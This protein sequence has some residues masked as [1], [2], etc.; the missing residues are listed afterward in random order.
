MLYYLDESTQEKVRYAVPADRR[1]PAT[2][3][4]DI[5]DQN[6]DA[7]PFLAYAFMDDDKLAECQENPEGCD[8]DWSWA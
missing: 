5:T 4:T 2:G 8:P 1:D 7:F 6:G 3:C